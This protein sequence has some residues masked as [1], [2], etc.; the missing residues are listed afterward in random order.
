MVDEDSE[1]IGQ[2]VIETVENVRRAKSEK[3]V[4][5]KEP[6]KQLFIKAKLTPAEFGMIEEEIKAA[7]HA[8][9]IE[10]TQL[11][12]ESEMSFGCELEL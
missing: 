1:R 12:S 11:D 3:Q 5:L 10:Y 7:T 8:E 9:D 2:V 6:V 4:S